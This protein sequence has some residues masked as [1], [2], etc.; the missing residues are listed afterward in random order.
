MMKSE[1]GPPL[2]LGAS[3]QLVGD[4][5]V[6]D[7]QLKRSGISIEILVSVWGRAPEGCRSGCGW[8]APPDSALPK[9]QHPAATFGQCIVDGLLK[10]ILKKWFGEPRQ[11][12]IDLRRQLGKARG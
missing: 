2:M 4:E 10:V 12:G 7:R 5:H 8:D 6:G 1:P 9:L 11:Q 3:L